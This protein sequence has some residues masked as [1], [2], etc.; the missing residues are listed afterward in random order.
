MIKNNPLTKGQLHFLEN[1]NLLFIPI[2]KTG[3]SSIKYL[4]SQYADY[5][6]SYPDDIMQYKH[7]YSFSIVR[8]PWDRMV[9][10]FKNKIQQPNGV[11]EKTGVDV[12]LSKYGNKFFPQMTFKDFLKAISS[13]DP[14]KLDEHIACQH[15]FIC[16]VN[17]NV[18]VDYI[19]KFE[20]ITKDIETIWSNVSLKYENNFPHLNKTNHDHYH[21]YYDEECLDIV[22]KIDGFVEDA[23]IFGYEF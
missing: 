14:D 20:K 5:K 10:C 1:A 22:Q 9:S 4:M 12:I 23:T 6:V 13:I 7:H 19:G 11:D 21:K 8:N 15:Q 3:C 18:I 2:A 17:K 16:D